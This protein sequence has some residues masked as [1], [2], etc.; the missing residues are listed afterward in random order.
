MKKR[1]EGEFYFLRMIVQAKMEEPT[2][3]F[4]LQGG[5]NMVSVRHVVDHN[6]KMI[7]SAWRL[8]VSE[9]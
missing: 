2:F 5:E 1:F 8:F 6:S 4:S 7:M 9:N 3:Y